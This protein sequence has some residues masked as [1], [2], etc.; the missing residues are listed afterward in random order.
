MEFRWAALAASDLENISRH[1]ARDNPAAARRVA[2]MLYAGAMSLDTM[3]NRGRIGRMAD[4]RELV[5]SPYVIAIGSG[6]PR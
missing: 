1:I 4:T 2:Q 3:P 6:E 5:L